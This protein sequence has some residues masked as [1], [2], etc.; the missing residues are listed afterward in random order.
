MVFTGDGQYFTVSG[1]LPL[2]YYS[3]PDYWGEYVCNTW[4]GQN[5]QDCTVVVQDF[6]GGSDPY[7]RNGQGSPGAQLQIERTNATLGTDI[8]D[9]ACWQI[10]LGLAASQDLQGFQA[11]SLFNLASNT[12]QRLGPNVKAI[13]GNTSNFQYGY[14]Q[15]LSD[16]SEAYALRLVGEDYWAQDPLWKTQ[17][18]GY[19]TFSPPCIR[20][21]RGS[22]TWPDWK[23]ITGEN[24]WA[25]FLGA[26]QL[27][28][29]QYQSQGYIPFKSESIQNAL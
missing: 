14:L 2:S 1:P 12:T 11:T 26:L 25:F 22:I 27:D 23:P 10:A 4:A 13:R 21:N 15:T 24:A 3:T 17:Y 5:N 29:W 8:Y 7:Y 20:Y 19:I 18:Q 9:A 28:S 16:A 6:G